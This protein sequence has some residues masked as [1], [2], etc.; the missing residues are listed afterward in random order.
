VEITS[1]L[2]EVNKLKILYLTNVPSPYIVCFLNELGKFCDLTAVFEKSAST[3]RDNS[4]NKCQFSTFNGIVLNGI[5]TDVDKAICPQIVKYLK[6]NVYDYIM[7]ANP[8]TPTGIIAIE[9]LK[10]RKIP[11]VLQSEGGFAKSGKGIKER[12]KKH[13]MSGAKL[14]FSAT[15]TGDKYFITYGAK[16]EQIVRY[17]FTS[18]YEKDL[19]TAVPTKQE[20]LNIRKKLGIEEKKIILSIGRFIYRKGFDILLSACKDVDKTVGIYIVGGTPIEEYIKL[21]QDLNLDNVHFVD[22]KSKDEIKE[23]YKMADLF[24][25]PTR[26]DTYGLVINEAMASGLPIITTD[27]CIAGLELV[28]DYENGFIVSVG[29][30]KELAGKMNVILN[31]DELREKIAKKSLEKIQ[32]YTFENMAKSHMEIFERNSC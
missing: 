6:K 32:W 23:Y 9:Y 13:L 30:E 7:V 26:E 27:K 22:F 3:E 25:L 4:W 17:P 5:S 20:K 15:E 21:K 11:F 16:K 18:F 14:Y 2:S 19:V 24:V 28:K 1:L 8:A 10:F 12:F 31:D 29:D